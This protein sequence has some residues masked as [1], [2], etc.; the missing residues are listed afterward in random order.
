MR[1]FA[2]S[3][4][5]GPKSALKMVKNDLF[6]V[7]FVSRVAEK[8]LDKIYGLPFDQGAFFDVAFFGLFVRVIRPMTQTNVS[9]RIK[10]LN[11][12]ILKASS[13]WIFDDDD[14][15]LISFTKIFQPSK[16]FSTA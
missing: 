7:S 12:D 2:N 9:Q 10:N 5:T 13:D 16:Q 4:L 3:G 14:G 11:K 15:G 1:N 8:G 6:R